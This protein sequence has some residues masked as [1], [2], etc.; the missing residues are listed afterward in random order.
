M[1][2]PDFVIIGAMKC[3]TSTMAAQ[4]AAQPGVFMSTPKEPNFFSDDDI[5]A[6]G[7]DWYE[8]LFAGAAPS[9][10]RGE[11]STHY[12]KRPTYPAT[13]A[14]MAKLLPVPRL[15]YIIRNPVERAVSHYIHAWSEGLMQQDPAAA[16]DADR[17]LVDY[18]LYGMQIAPFVECFGAGAVHLTSLE[19]IGADPQG[20]LERVCTFIGLAPKPVW[21]DDLGAQNVSAERFRP[22]PMHGLLVDNRVARTLRRTLVP[23]RLRERV[24]NARTIGSRPEIPPALRRVLEVRFA[25]DRDYLATLFPGHPV[26]RAAYP[27]LETEA[28]A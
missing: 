13:V 27:F 4:L 21:R 11:A 9:D 23:K 1:A 12:T 22:L 28:P 17:T 14:R 25:E 10:L 2:G 6:R 20:E 19:Q 7:R 3:G 8:S 18:S 15:V 26:L 5:Y 16:F 24:R